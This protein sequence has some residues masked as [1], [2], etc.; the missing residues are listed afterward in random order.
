M[1]H[2]YFCAPKDHEFDFCDMCNKTIYKMAWKNAEG[3]QFCTLACAQE[4]ESKWPPY[5]SHTYSYKDRS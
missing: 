5:K 2:G 4:W 1:T 3:E